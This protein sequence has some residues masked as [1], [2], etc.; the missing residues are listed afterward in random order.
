[1][2]HKNKS[3]SINVNLLIMK[4]LHSFLGK[5]KSFLF[6]V[7]MTALFAPELMFGQNQLT[8]Y[9][10]GNNNTL[11]PYSYY[12]RTKWQKCEFVVPA[13]ALAGMDARAQAPKLISDLT[14]YYSWYGYN[15]E[16]CNFK[17]FVE[18]VDFDSFEGQTSFHGYD[19]ATIV[20][21]GR[22]N[23]SEYKVKVSFDENFV[24]HGGNLLIG[25][26]PTK[27]QYYSDGSAYF[28]GTI[29]AN[30]A[31]EGYD[32]DAD[33]IPAN[34]INFIPKT[35]FTYY[36]E[37]YCFAPKNL[38]F[39]ETSITSTSV[40]LD[41]TPLGH[42][43][44]WKIKCS[45]WDPDEEEYIESIVDGITEHPYTL[46]GL[47]P[48]TYYS[49]SV[50]ADCG[51]DNTSDWS[52]STEF[53]TNCSEY[54]TVPLNEGFENEFP[55][56]WSIY[57]SGYYGNYVYTTS[58][59]G[60][61]EGNYGLLFNMQDV[62]TAYYAIL[63]AIANLDECQISF[64]AMSPEEW[65][66]TGAFSVGIMSDPTDPSTFV[67]IKTFDCTYEWMEYKAYFDHYT[68]NGTHIAIKLDGDYPGMLLLDDVSV[69]PIEANACFD[70]DALV[71]A[72][73]GM[74][75]AVVSWTA[76]GNESN[77]QVQYRTEDEEW[78][79]ESALVATSSYAMEDL[80]P[81][82]TYYVRVRAYC[83]AE[84]QSGWTQM[85]FTTPFCDPENQCDIHYVLRT[86]GN[87]GWEGNYIDVYNEDDALV[88]TLTV[89]NG[90]EKEGELYL[91]DGSTYSFVLRIDYPWSL[92]Y[93]SFDIYGPDGNLIEG[94]SYSEGAMPT[95][96]YGDEITLLSG[97]EMVLP[98]LQKT[99][100]PDSRQYHL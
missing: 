18:E 21:N 45:V 8:V 53:M 82:V 81:D 7:L 37:D 46:S 2:P 84:S 39:D 48:A 71:P 78:P 24:Y 93:L 80:E 30:A 76:H 69:E 43:Q 87:W 17:V 57:G 25:M 68:G 6:M 67:T 50:A 40:E 11:V 85:S 73:V 36:D 86:S 88:G 19:N 28:Y 1:M 29:V 27:K 94:L 58:Y 26:Y 51:N 13:S 66:P 75:S 10:G 63:P 96:D 23:Y 34:I 12:N 70:V 5:S 60:C 44:E 4:S 79:E 33:N 3:P 31:M 90:S 65:Y 99:Q 74:N 77:W 16:L 62:N 56:C 89:E 22:L 54:A 100:E 38:V 52:Y 47:E 83:S 91:C 92:E 9:D 35:T 59:Y 64:Y 49:V 61:P 14:F 32:D 97:Y 72:Y 55:V 41:W 20:Y 42:E 95:G 15:T 98:R